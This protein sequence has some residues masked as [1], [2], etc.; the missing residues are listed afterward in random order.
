MVSGLKNIDFSFNMYYI[1]FQLE[2]K[3][4]STSNPHRKT[5][6]YTQTKMHTKNWIF[7]IAN[8]FISSLRIRKLILKLIR[9][10]KLHAR[11]KKKTQD[12]S[13]EFEMCIHACP[14]NLHGRPRLYCAI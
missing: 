10:Q 13:R 8:Y 4:S 6:S 12:S 7:F 3:F 2:R 5:F 9:S 14:S 11:R 1:Q